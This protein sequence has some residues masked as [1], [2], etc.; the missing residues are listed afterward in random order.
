MGERDTLLEEAIISMGL[1]GNSKM[2]F[3]TTVDL[4]SLLAVV[5]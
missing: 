2:L 5:L 4:G 1:A 3:L